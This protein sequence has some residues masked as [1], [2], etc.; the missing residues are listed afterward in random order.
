[1]NEMR[2]LMES[3]S[4][5]DE[6][7]RR[8]PI[9]VEYRDP[10][11]EFIV[12]YRASRGYYAEGEGVDRAPSFENLEDAIEHGELCISSGL[13]CEIEEEIKGG[14]PGGRPFIDLSG[15]DGNAFVIMGRAKGYA[16]QLGLDG[17]AIV[18]EMQ[19]SD[20]EN[21]LNVFDKYFGEYVDLYRGDSD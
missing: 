18:A 12:K 9:Y 16:K 20:Y 19:E 6:Y 5:L 2:K 1:M 4:Q 13:G 11:G 7:D 15:P 10:D 21:L 14:I 17:E 8:E 3:V